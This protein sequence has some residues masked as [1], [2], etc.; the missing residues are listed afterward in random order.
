MLRR[1]APRKGDM[2]DPATPKRSRLARAV[3]QA[4]PGTFAIFFAFFLADGIVLA[5]ESV[6][7]L[8]ESYYPNLLARLGVAALVY[9]LTKRHVEILHQV[10]GESI[11]QWMKEWATK[12]TLKEGLVI[13]V[14]LVI[15]VAMLVIVEVEPS[16]H[17][18]SEAWN[19][20]L[21]LM[22]T[23]VFFL[24]FLVLSWVLWHTPKRP[25]WLGGQ[26]VRWDVVVQLSSIWCVLFLMTGILVIVLV[27][28]FMF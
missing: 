21:L 22:G 7:S 28:A 20:A 27:L 11:W 15:T 9:V 12:W 24:I 4:I 6:F 25:R 18:R 8:P 19:K 3:I 23:S 13:G 5:L 17:E 26:G 10:G 16:S 2:T 14:I 1:D